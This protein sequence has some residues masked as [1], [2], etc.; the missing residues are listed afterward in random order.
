ML[1]RYIKKIKTSGDVNIPTGT[2]I[3]V[4]SPLLNDFPQL[5]NYLWAVK[6]VSV[7][8]DVSKE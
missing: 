7:N 6:S 2:G 8:S 1:S 4:P 3:V 5:I